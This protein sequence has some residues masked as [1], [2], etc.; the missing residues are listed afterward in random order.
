MKSITFRYPK[1]ISLFRSGS[2][3]TH[4]IFLF[5]SNFKY[6]KHKKTEIKLPN[7]LF[8]IKSCFPLKLRMKKQKEIV[9]RFPVKVEFYEDSETK[10]QNV[11]RKLINASD[12][13]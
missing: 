13:K 10:R 5:N 11:I 8:K 2:C 1:F 6:S 12:V 4:F 3:F 9:L 7:N